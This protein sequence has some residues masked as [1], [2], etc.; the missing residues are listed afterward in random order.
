MNPRDQ[1]LERDDVTLAREVD[2]RRALRDRRLK[3]S[4]LAPFGGWLGVGALRV[5]RVRTGDED[6]AELVTGYESYRR[7]DSQPA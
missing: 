6:S 4:V 1:R 7:V 5:L 2:A 3:L